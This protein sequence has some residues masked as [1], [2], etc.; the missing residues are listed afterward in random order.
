[1]R[2]IRKGTE[3]RSLTLHRT[4]QHASYDNYQPKDELRQSLVAEQQGICCYCMQRI[5]P[6]GAGM[7]I[8]H[9]HCQTLYRAEELEYRNL[10]A[11]CTGNEGQ[12]YK[13]QTCDTRKGDRSLDRNPADPAH[14]IEAFVRFLGDGRI[15]SANP[16]F[17][18][19]LNDV[20]NLNHPFLVSNRKAVLRSF[21]DSLGQGGKTANFWQRK[22][23]EW[24]GDN[25]GQLREYCGVVVYWLRKKL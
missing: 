11:A 10:L 19:Q 7:K 15:E 16:A 12:P 21:L 22:L 20:L 9:W 1:M 24:N 4:S 8:E 18:Q 5:Q 23:S 2:A 13:E 14:R 6:T 17:D 25:G 3:P